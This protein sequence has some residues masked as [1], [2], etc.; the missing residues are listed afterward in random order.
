MRANQEGFP[1]VCL[2]PGNGCVSTDVLLA[3]PDPERSEENGLQEWLLSA[4][5]GPGVSF[6][7]LSSDGFVV[8]DF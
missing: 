6:V 3:I 8:S 1:S 5:V 2:H 7:S 4:Q